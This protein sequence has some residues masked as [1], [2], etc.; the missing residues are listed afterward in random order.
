MAPSRVDAACPSTGIGDFGGPV[1]VA[2]GDQRP[3][4]GDHPSRQMLDAEPRSWWRRL[5]ACDPTRSLAI[6]ELHEQ[7]RREA[8]FH[9][10]RLV[11]HLADFPR[12]DIEDLATQ[13]ADDSLIV[14]L[15]KLE[16]YRG[17]SQFLTW[18]RKFA[19]LEAHVSI[20]RRRGR[21]RVGISWDPECA[22]LIA[23][24][25]RSAQELVETRELLRTVSDLVVNKLTARQ[26][27]VL[28]AIAVNGVSTNTLAGELHTT[29]G[30]IYKSLHDARAKLRPL[31][32]SAC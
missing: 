14:L 30:A 17:D 12:S 20:R 16:D 28:I 29:P 25:G 22:L 4:A 6:A 26:R 13:A 27:T 18:A 8:A 5:H 24:P 21:D 7:L 15:R 9:I 32:A 19:A 23:D 31:L 2:V 3:L 11:A 10:R 1:D